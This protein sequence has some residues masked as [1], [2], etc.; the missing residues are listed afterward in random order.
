V[1]AAREV[2]RT[3]AGLASIAMKCSLPLNAIET[4]SLLYAIQCNAHQ[5]LNKQAGTAGVALG[6]FPYTSMMNHSCFP[7]C[8]HR[9]HIEQGKPPRLILRAITDI[10]EGEELCYSYVGLYQSTAHR[11]EQLHRAYS[12]KCIC[13]R[14]SAGDPSC[15]AESSSSS[16]SSCDLDICDDRAIDQIEGSTDP[17]KVADVEQFVSSVTNKLGIDTK[18]QLETFLLGDD[19]GVFHPAHRILF[20]CYYSACV[21]SLRAAI[22]DSKAT[23]APSLRN[24]IGF[25]LLALGCMRKYVTRLQTEMGYLEE[26]VVQAM[27]LLGDMKAVEAKPLQPRVEGKEGITGQSAVDILFA[28]GYLMGSYWG[29]RVDERVRDLVRIACGLSALPDDLPP[30]IEISSSGG[31]SICKSDS[32]HTKDEHYRSEEE[33][34]KSLITKLRSS[35][36]LIAHVCRSD[37]EVD[38]VVSNLEAQIAV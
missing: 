31:S 25:G 29:A 5:I 8:I 33:M 30:L 11:R 15:A 14:C 7:N 19:A 9:F 34:L 17:S 3:A 6:L 12:F 2:S 1:A 16:S 13:E 26:Q 20:L 35:S 21:S 18:V 36:E 22:A 10:K 38:D 28:C 37:V 24:C 32:M 27:A 4:R 23:T